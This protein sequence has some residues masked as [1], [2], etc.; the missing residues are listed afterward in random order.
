MEFVTDGGDR[1]S[2]DSNVFQTW[3]EPGDLRI[4][5]YLDE[6]DLQFIAAELD[7]QDERSF[8]HVL[9]SRN[10]SLLISDAIELESNVFGDVDRERV[11]WV[12]SALEHGIR[13]CDEALARPDLPGG[14]RRA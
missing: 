7:T 10:L 9:L 14:S 8:P 6:N 13:M 2:V 4:D 5:V 3:P 1:C 11:R 12:R